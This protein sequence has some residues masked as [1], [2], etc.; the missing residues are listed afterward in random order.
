MARFVWRLVR[1]LWIISWLLWCRLL[2]EISRNG[3][4][5][6]KIDAILNYPLGVQILKRNLID[7]EVPTKAKQLVEKS[8]SQFK[9]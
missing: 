6:T 3:A 4:E 8:K 1:R 9:N 7:V 2:I 5:F